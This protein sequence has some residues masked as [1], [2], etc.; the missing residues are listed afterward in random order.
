M[1]TMCSETN[2]LLIDLVTACQLIAHFKDVQTKQTKAWE[3]LRFLEKNI[4]YY[5]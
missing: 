5:M 4:G 1:D 3:S 2:T